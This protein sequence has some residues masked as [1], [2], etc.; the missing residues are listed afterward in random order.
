M[1]SHFLLSY[2]KIS[3]CS[4]QFINWEN[5]NSETKG[6]PA[7]PAKTLLDEQTHY[8]GF[9]IST[10]LMKMSKNLVF[11]NR[12]VKIQHNRAPTH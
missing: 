1:L 11:P 10:N 4:G 3:C 12:Y 7:E 6:D 2:F 5:L 9:K 8:R